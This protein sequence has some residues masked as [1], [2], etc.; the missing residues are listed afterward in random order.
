MPHRLITDTG[1]T[2]ADIV[3]E[4]NGSLSDR[5][6]FVGSHP[7]AGSEKN[8]PEHARADLFEG[9]VVV[10]TPTQKTSDAD[11]RRTADFWIS[12]GATVLTMSPEA[13]DQALAA[14][15]HLPHLVAAALRG[16]RRSKICQ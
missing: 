5:A 8:G 11:V 2:K 10:V 15:S 14:T 16:S 6:A 3:R 1:S 7:L 13:H 4:V 12:L 9:R